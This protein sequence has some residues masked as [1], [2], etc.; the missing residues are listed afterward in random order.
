MTSKKP[1]DAD[2]TWFGTREWQEGEGEADEDIRAGR[3][4]GPFRTAA[5]LK[6]HLAGGSRPP[7]AHRDT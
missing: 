1:V 2:Q 3:V 4:S 5:E 6:K 7:S